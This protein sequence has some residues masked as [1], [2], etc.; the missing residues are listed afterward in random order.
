MVLVLV[1]VLIYW[2]NLFSKRELVW[3]EGRQS[4][5]AH[6]LRGSRET[7]A[8]MTGEDFVCTRLCSCAYVSDICVCGSLDPL[9]SVC[10]L[11]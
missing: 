7:P 5:L 10:V 8:R 2:T 11:T 4:R 3:V 1:T 6:R 9:L